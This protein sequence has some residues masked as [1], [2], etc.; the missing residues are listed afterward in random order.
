MR[1]VVIESPYAGAVTAN[2]EYAKR[3]VLDCLK[4]G[5]APYASHLFFTQEGL[6]DDHKPDE[7]RLGIEA[8]FA[9]GRAADL[10][11]FYVDLGVSKGMRGGYREAWGRGANIEIRA[12]YRETTDED[13]IA[14]SE[15]E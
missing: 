8:G 6:L 2:V 12:L 7:R 9:W 3:C 4:R 1:R 11:A 5:E 10:V 15:E 14:L 13:R